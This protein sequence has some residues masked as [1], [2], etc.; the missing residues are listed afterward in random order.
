MEK[1]YRPYVEKPGDPRKWDTREHLPVDSW[2]NALKWTDDIVRDIILG[3]RER[4]LENETL[5]LM[6]DFLR[7]QTLTVDT[8]I[9]VFH[10]SGN[11]ARQSRTHITNHT[12]S[13]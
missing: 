5:F 2:L 3:F 13:L 9:T 8:E 12:A 6:Y 1:N 4:G 10:L 7:W 11:G